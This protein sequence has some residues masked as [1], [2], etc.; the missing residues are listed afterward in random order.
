MRPNDPT[1][2]TWAQ[3]CN[4]LEEA[5]QMHRRF[6]RLAV[7][8]QPQ[9]TTWEPPV[10]VFE[11]DAEFVV[12]V[13]LP[14]VAEERVEMVIEGRDL[15]IR[16]DSRLPLAGSRHAV[17]RLEIPY[18]YFERRVQLPAARLEAGTREFRDGCLILRL[19]KYER[20]EGI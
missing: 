19:R 10:D 3:A 16:A 2:W 14:G 6:F 13:A 11:N 7:S 17:R 5:D 20:I 8:S 4:M 9:R 15:V 1:D 12:V 18:G